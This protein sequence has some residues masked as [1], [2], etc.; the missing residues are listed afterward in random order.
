MLFVL[1]SANK[2]QEKSQVF[3]HVDAR[4]VHSRPIQRSHRVAIV[5]NTV[6]TS[7]V[8]SCTAPFDSAKHS[9]SA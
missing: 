8:V 7:C 2:P 1:R 6:F 4:F 9:S 5:E 3:S